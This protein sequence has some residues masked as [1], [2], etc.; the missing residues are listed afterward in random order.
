[1]NEVKLQGQITSDPEVKESRN[2]ILRG[3]FLLTTKG[4][5]EDRPRYDYIRCVIWDEKAQYVVDHFEKV[6]LCLL[7]EVSEDAFIQIVQEQLHMLW[8]SIQN[9]WYVK[10]LTIH[11]RTCINDD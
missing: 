4:G 7:K 8:K 6:S 9:I 1:M 2:G 11:S 3:S 5:T 10:I